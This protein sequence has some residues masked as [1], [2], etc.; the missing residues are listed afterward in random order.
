VVAAHI[1]AFFA[2][3]HNQEVI[4]KLR[5]PEIGAITWKQPSPA[6][7]AAPAAFKGDVG[8]WTGKT[9]V[10][11]GTLSLPREELKRRLE[12]LG[13]KVT[14]SVSRNTD[15]LIAGRDSG[16]KLARAQALGIEVL[17]EEQLDDLLDA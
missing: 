15:V 5:S 7:G 4:R 9:V 1:R 8:R 10:I 12:R 6:S 2:Q 3:P 13:S 14:G 11:T 16:S 17:G